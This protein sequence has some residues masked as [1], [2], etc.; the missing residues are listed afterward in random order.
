[1]VLTSIEHVAQKLERIHARAAELMRGDKP[2]EPL[3]EDDRLASVELRLP[4][5]TRTF[6]LSAL[7]ADIVVC[8]LAAEC[9]PY[10]RL[11]LRATQRELGRPCLEIGTIV[12]LLGLS[13]RDFPEVK[14]AFAPPAPLRRWAIVE[15]DDGNETVPLVSHKARIDAR[16]AGHL[17]GEDQ[18]PA[19]MALHRPDDGGDAGA[20]PALAER[21]QQARQ[22]GEPLV[23]ELVGR[24][25]AA[26]E[27][28]VRRIARALSCA[29]VTLDAGELEA[30]QLG[31]RLAALRREAHLGAAMP[32]LL[33]WDALAVRPLASAS[34]EASAAQ[35]AKPK[36]PAALTRWID[37]HDDI[38]FLV[39]EEQE[40]LLGR[41]AQSLVTV[42]VPFPSPHE[43]ARLL[44]EA[45]AVRGLAPA[46]DVDLAT[47]TR[48]FALDAPLITI[49]ARAAD[50]AARARERDTRIVQHKE[51]VDACR[52]QVRH[53][54]KSV[55]ERVEHSHRW[56]DL[57][58]P[59]DVYESLREMIS[60]VRHATK[61]YDEWGFG[62]R[63][64]VSQGVSALFAGPPGT[65]K[66]MCAS[67]MARELDME[68][69]R[70]DLS[71]VVSK[72]IGET[73][74]NLSKVFDEAQHS[75][76]IILFDEADSLFARRTE[77]KS[78]VDRY[79]NL[80]V[81][82]LLQ[83]ME[84]FGGVTILT[85]NFEDAIDSAFKR[86]LTFKMRFEK[87][88]AEARGALW[89]KMF[90]ASC[91]LAPDVDVA[92]LGGLYE[93]SGGNIRGAAIRAAFLAAE[94][95][96]PI[97]MAICRQAAEREAR[98]MGVLIRSSAQARPATERDNDDEPPPPTG[99][100]RTPTSARLVPI[101]HPRRS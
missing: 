40:P 100:P 42:T 22:R 74:K 51:L 101:T 56:E 52:R 85:T 89:E 19:G 33:R 11:L 67:V 25:S 87:P 90:P 18:L 59:V 41:H 45:L 55:A 44:E 54:L 61:V 43:R 7:E 29:L 37:D 96:S 34:E 23:V 47:V 82:Y 80:E 77:V 21:V 39:G 5:L 6:G 8:L 49:A 13:F 76:A 24:S 12:E 50:E 94:A 86:R 36:L 28:L 99:E 92:T 88:D 30:A 4:G 65:G 3:G 73:E 20:P 68:L 69:F 71:R 53:D 66:T 78:S 31:H 98:E 58:I 9:D 72:W 2:T 17:L 84:A 75:N 63:H 16:V 57:V 26:C 46:P 70:V 79:A 83:R 15:Y 10:F 95:S 27:A 81:N 62:G 60:Y 48:R 32:V 91:V 93:M 97:T 35:A 14:R 64:G 1:M 38:M